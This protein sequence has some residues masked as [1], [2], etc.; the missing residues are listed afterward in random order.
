MEEPCTN[1]TRFGL[2]STVLRRT[3]ASTSRR[4]V[5]QQP[6][7]V[8]L[9]RLGAEHGHGGAAGLREVR[10]VESGGGRRTRRVGRRGSQR[11]RPPRARPPRSGRGAGGGSCSRARPQRFEQRVG[12]GR[13][14]RPGDRKG[15]LEERRPSRDLSE[16][17]R[18]SEGSS[19]SIPWRRNATSACAT[20]SPPGSSRQLLAEERER[21]RQEPFR[22]RAEARSAPWRSSA[23]NRA[24]RRR[25]RTRCRSSSR[26]LR[27]DAS[28]EA[29]QPRFRVAASS[30]VSTFTA[31]RTRAVGS[32][33]DRAS[34]VQPQAVRRSGSGA[35]G[36]GR[37]RCA[38]AYASA[39][40]AAAGSVERERGERR[41][42]WVRRDDRR[43]RRIR[44]R[45]ADGQRASGAHAV[46]EG[47]RQERRGL[48]L[49]LPR[50][51]HRK[52]AVRSTKARERPDER[53][54]EAR[55]AH[56][57]PIVPA[58]PSIHRPGFMRA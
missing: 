53:G 26:R 1:S 56:Q 13:K 38:I 42:S 3:S 18:R 15:P 20:V 5:E 14:R 44:R 12:P 36:S 9:V 8:A 31:R 27:T 39:R 52:P 47:E 17:R 7:E 45:A 54:V 37:P 11:R 32:A 16:A 50:D 43:A 22:P 21:T 24:G 58:A 49:G 10:A 55:G 57:I 40:R 23:R 35:F 41:E 29:R 4:P 2:S 25:R 19:S 51:A 6:L 28:A 34:S 33:S 46:V 30:G 48:D